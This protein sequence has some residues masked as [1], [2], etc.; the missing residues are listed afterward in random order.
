MRCF[1]C[2]SKQKGMKL[3]K[4][5]ASFT[6]LTKIYFVIWR[7]ILKQKAFCIN[8]LYATTQKNLTDK[9]LCKS[10]QPWK[11]LGFLYE[12]QEVWT[13]AAS[14]QGVVLT[15]KGPKGALCLA[16]WPIPVSVCWLCACIHMSRFTELYTSDLFIVH[17]LNLKVLGFFSVTCCRREYKISVF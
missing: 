5:S 9:M 2:K 1:I 10:H 17:M 8:E 14:E 7:T 16:G 15:R 13:V 4:I 12:T 11:V 3:C 6:F